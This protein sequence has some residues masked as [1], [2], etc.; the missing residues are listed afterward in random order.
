[1]KALFLP[2]E[3]YVPSPA[4]RIE[5][6]DEETVR[7]VNENQLNIERIAAPGQYIVDIIPALK[8]LPSWLA[9]FKRESTVHNKKEVEL[10]SDLVEDVRR[11]L[12]AGKAGPSFTRMW[13]ENRQDCSMSDL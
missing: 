13:L 5:T 2:Y 6:D 7:K 1:M 9:S 8:H 12:Q 11:D 3:W 4:G 10:F